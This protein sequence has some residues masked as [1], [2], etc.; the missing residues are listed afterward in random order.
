VSEPKEAEIIING[1]K[2]TFGQSMTVRVA[3]A[4]M[5]ME[6][7][8]PNALGE[9]EHGRAMTQGYRARAS[10]VQDFIFKNLT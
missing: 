2:L 1:H 8:D 9:D 5:L 3:I 4:N 10:E 7:A 6:F